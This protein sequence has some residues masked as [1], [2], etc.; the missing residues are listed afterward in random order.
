M[1]EKFW[2]LCRVRLIMDR[3][4]RIRSDFCSLSQGEVQEFT[5]NSVHIIYSIFMVRG[6]DSLVVNLLSDNNVNAIK[7]KTLNKQ[8]STVNIVTLRFVC[9]K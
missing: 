5:G 4:L 8:R 6:Q 7:G 3:K 2:L 9:S 1:T